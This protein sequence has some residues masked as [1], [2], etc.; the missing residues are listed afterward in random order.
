MTNASLPQ[1]KNGYWSI[2]VWTVS[3]KCGR[4]CSNRPM[5]LNSIGNKVGHQQIAIFLES[6]LLA[7]QFS[8]TLKKK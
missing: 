8:A 6:M 3:S 5:S 2:I 7:L 4:N 1:N